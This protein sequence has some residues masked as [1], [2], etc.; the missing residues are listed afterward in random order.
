MVVGKPIKVDRIQVKLGN[1]F[2]SV[3]IRFANPQIRFD[4]KQ[5]NKTCL[6]VHFEP[7]YSRRTLGETR[8]HFLL[9][10]SPFCVSF[11]SPALGLNRKKLE[12]TEQRV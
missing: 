7:K 4:G 3:F 11:I 9:G 2:A 1:I 8:P 6:F 5:A 12:G 10:P